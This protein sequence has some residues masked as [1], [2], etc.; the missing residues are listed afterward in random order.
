MPAC[1]AN[2]QYSYSNR[3]KSNIG[4]PS[5]RC[6]KQHNSNLAH[7]SPTQATMQNNKHRTTTTT[8]PWRWSNACPALGTVLSL[9]CCLFSCVSLACVSWCFDWLCGSCVPEPVTAW[10]GWLL[11]KL[12]LSIGSWLC[13]L[14][15]GF[16]WA[17]ET[18]Q[19]LNRKQQPTSNTLKQNKCFVFQ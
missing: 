11:L 7:A 13:I 8:L 19:I 14:G 16:V 15:H 18:K 17:S 12:V 4:E 1:A 2:E 5:S 3:T 9:G 10:P 6:V